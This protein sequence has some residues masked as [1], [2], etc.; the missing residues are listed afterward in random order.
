[1]TKFDKRFAI[2]T[3]VK[4][5]GIEGFQA[6]KDINSVRNLIQVKGWTG[7]FQRGHVISFTNA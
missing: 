5:Q 1:M 4:L 7:S 2:G 6:I 3:K